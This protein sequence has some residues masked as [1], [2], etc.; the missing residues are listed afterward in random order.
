MT[1][2]FGIILPTYSAAAELRLCVE[3][4]RRNS[5]LEN[6]LIVLVDPCRDGKPHRDVIAV[7]EDIDAPY[8]L[9]ERRLGPYGSWNLGARL[10][11][12]D[13]LCFITDDQY[14]AP[15]WDEPLLRHLDEYP[16]LTSVLVEPGIVRPYHTNLMHDFGHR[17]T[18][19]DEQAFLQ[20]VARNWEDRVGYDGF[21]I[22]T[23]IHRRLFDRLTGWPDGLPFPYPNDFLFREK[24][25]GLGLEY[26]RVLT[27]YSYHFQKSSSDPQ[28]P[29]TLYFER[30][31]DVRQPP[32]L[33]QLLSNV[34][35]RAAG[36]YSRFHRSPPRIRVSG[37]RWPKK[38]DAGL[39]YK[40][41]IGR[42][43]EIGAGA[44]RI[45]NI[46]TITVDLSRELRN[47]KN[48]VF[49]PPDIVGTAYDVHMLPDESLDFVVNSHLMEH[50]I[51]PL[52]A[53]LEWKRFL[54]PAGIFLMIVPDTRCKPVDRD[55]PETTID[56][57]VERHQLGL[58]ETLDDNPKTSC[59][60]DRRNAEFTPSGEPGWRHFNY[61][62]PETFLPLIRVAGLEVVEVLE[63]AT[64]KQG[65]DSQRWN[66]DDFTV[67]ARKS[68]IS[69][70][71]GQ[72]Y[73]WLTYAGQDR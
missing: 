20:F 57:I 4:L 67:V 54:K 35:S 46:N 28:E 18:E 10:V 2:G 59:L 19:F 24:L 70:P 13:V 68:S 33:R 43:V 61:W 55:Y 42:G 26:H 31:D 37:Y 7:L 14:F 6:N 71:Q 5:Q 56:E 16:V 60:G 38:A 8:K 23:V 48:S 44:W 32:L 65:L 62:T 12:D 21:Y 52:G 63:A 64:K 3:S 11:K 41:C 29:R 39:I 49:P 51:D 40:Y 25:H 50:L 15:S 1:K 73:T 58:R 72:F 45:P 69:D 36:L 27:S 17:A 47:G 22:P 66:Y 9:N 53:L 34:K 30:P